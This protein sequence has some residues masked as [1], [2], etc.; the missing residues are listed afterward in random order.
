MKTAFDHIDSRG[1]MHSSDWDRQQAES[2]YARERDQ[3]GKDLTA[4]AKYGAIQ[5]ARAAE[6][7]EEQNALLAEQNKLL[8]MSPEERAAYKESLEKAKRQEQRRK[9][10]EA[11]YWSSP[12]GVNARKLAEEQAKRAE[13]QARQE[14][15]RQLGKFLRIHLL[16]FIA[17]VCG[18]FILNELNEKQMDFVSVL[19]AGVFFGFFSGGFLAFIIFNFLRRNE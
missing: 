18:F 15:L 2:K 14:S 12:A 17:I 1:K 11:A 13:E 7:A 19:T 8:M 16:C 3:Q 6:A 5:S 4:A 9:A 10:E